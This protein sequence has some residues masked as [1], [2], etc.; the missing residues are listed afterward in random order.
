MGLGSYVFLTV[1][2]RSLGLAEFG[3]LSTM[4]VV[5]FGF[6]AGLWYPFEQELARVVASTSGVPSAADVRRVSRVQGA[7]ILAAGAVLLGYALIT[8]GSPDRLPD[9]LVAGLVASLL[10]LAVTA[11]QRGRLLGAQRYG[12]AAMQHTVDG[13]A[14]VA[15][16]IGCA[17]LG[18]DVGWYGIAR[19]LAPLAGVVAVR[20]RTPR[21]RTIA[22]STRPWSSLIRDLLGLLAGSY[23]S[24]ALLNVGPLVVR[25][26]S[27]VEATGSFMAIF[28]IARL[29]I[30]F[31]GVAASGFLPILVQAR[32]NAGMDG[33][34][35]LVRSAALV[36]LLVGV[37]GGLLLGLLGPTLAVL[38]FGEAY[39]VDRMASL[40]LALSSAGF[41]TAMLLQVSLVAMGRQRAVA[42]TWLLGAVTFAVALLLPIDVWTKVGVAYVVSSVV[43]V[44][45]MGAVVGLWR[46]PVAVRPQ[47]P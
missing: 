44:G 13:A 16:A 18:L 10:T 23:I 32:S 11:N 19:G 25:A 42:W 24:I 27:T 14:R 45:S 22:P 21:A 5:V 47:Q 2:A 33:F 37:A 35:R 29:P 26:G 36:V 20:P 6:I 41:V 39:S 30:Y 43:V 15:G 38:V 3:E 28:V 1:A 12:W 7:T 8:Q 46:R 4:W 31:A 40:L 17:V 9:G 34:L